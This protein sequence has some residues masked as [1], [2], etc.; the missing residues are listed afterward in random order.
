M[1]YEFNVHRMILCAVAVQCICEAYGISTQEEEDR[2]KYEIKT[3]LEVNNLY[4]KLVAP[5]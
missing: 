2:R 4:T 1:L 5:A 3:T